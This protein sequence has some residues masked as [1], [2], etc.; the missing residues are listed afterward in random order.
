MVWRL[1]RAALLE[2]ALPHVWLRLVAVVWLFRPVG[3]VQL[4]AGAF[5]EPSLRANAQAA[6]ADSR[7]PSGDAPF[8][9]AIQTA[10]ASAEALASAVG[11]AVSRAASRSGTSH[12]SADDVEGSAGFALAAR[13]RQTGHAPASPA[14]SVAP[15][16]VALAA[17]PPALERAAGSVPSLP[18]AA[19]ST[20]VAGASLPQGAMGMPS[21]PAARSANS[22][23]PSGAGVIVRGWGPVGTAFWRGSS[24]EG[25]N[26][27]EVAAD[28][29]ERHEGSPGNPSSSVSAQDDTVGTELRL[30]ING[31]IL[32]LPKLFWALVADVVAMAAFVL[33]IP[34]ILQISRR[35]RTPPSATAS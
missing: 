4:P 14:P 34:W 16:V 10:A 26:P 30:H 18:P 24:D 23:S 27:E 2:S 8:R 15:A 5:T 11:A 28:S 29:G 31:E 19:N 6:P 32:G 7:P 3:A 25:R 35:R 13:L 12:K 21:S 17:S 22:A 1:R 9:E 33:C 20:P